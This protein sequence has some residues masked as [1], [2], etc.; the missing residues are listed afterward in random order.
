[1]KN[2][3]PV[4][5]A[6]LAAAKGSPLLFLSLAA[7]IIISA[8]AGLLPP[9]VLGRAVDSLSTNAGLPL[10]LALGYFLSLALAGALDAGRE[11]LIT[12]SGQRMTHVLRGEMCR[13]LSR[14]PS[15]YL[16]RA[17]PGQLTSLFTGDVD[18]MEALFASG[19]VSMLADACRVIGILAIVSVKSRGLALMMLI[20]VPILGAFTCFCRKRMKLYSLRQ[21]RAMAVVAGHVPE[22]LACLGTIRLLGAQRYMEKRYDDSLGD[23]YSATEHMNLFDS[24]Y[25]PVI[26]VSS[27]VTVAVMMYLSSLG[28]LSGRLFGM[29]AGTAVAMIS[30]VTKVF[31]PIEAIGMEIQNIQT[32]MAGAYRINDFFS[33]EEAPRPSGTALPDPELPA[34]ELCG[35]TFG[36]DGS[37]DVIKDLS[38]KVARGENVTVTGRTGAGKSTLFKLILGL[39]PPKSGDIK[40]MGISPC[41]ISP[42]QRR[43]IFGYVEQ[44]FRPVPGTVKDQITLWDANL[45]DEM[46]RRAASLSGLDETI[47]RMPKGYDTPFDPS[48]FSQGQLQLLAIARAVASD[49]SVLML[50]EITAGLDSDTEERVLSALERASRGRAVISISHRFS[51]RA[52]GRTVSL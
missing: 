21:R 52:G 47:S 11:I 26:I 15:G 41:D 2:K 40:V 4:S 33:L 48:L 51:A 18:A 7:A 23:T 13:K 20:L 28:G 10:W 39:Y 3:M 31:E 19:V 5:R 1:M 50:D 24:I 32:A 42:E 8:L 17:D 35:V 43:H 22:A 6:V 30:Y 9:L 29:T 27:A 46:V 44:S 49:P 12:V 14:L 38:M 36:Y 37:R 34:V 45:S 16:A 25:S